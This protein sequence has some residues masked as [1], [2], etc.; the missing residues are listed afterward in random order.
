MESLACL[1]SCGLPRRSVPPRGLL[2]IQ[3]FPEELNRAGP[4]ARIVV[5]RVSVNLQVPAHEPPEK[6]HAILQV[7]APVDDGLAPGRG[8]RFNRFSVS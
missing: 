4:I 1:A 3:S 7:F 8:L 6:L 2:S 5:V